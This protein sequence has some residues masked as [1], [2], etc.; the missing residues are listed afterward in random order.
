MDVHK[1]YRFFQ[2]KFRLKRMR[3][4]SSLF[5]IDDKTRI[6]DVGGGKEN[7]QLIPARPWLTIVNIDARPET[8]GKTQ[9]EVGDGCALSFDN[10]A[11]DVAYSNSV[12]EHVGDWKSQIKFADEIRR[13]A[14]SYYVQTPNRR[15]FM[16]PHLL[17]PFIHFFPKTLQ[18]ILLKNFTVWGL[19][20]RPNRDYVKCFLDTTQ[21]LTVEQMRTLFPDAEIRREKWFG[22][23]KSIIA[24]RIKKA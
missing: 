8:Q 10:F 19:I 23:T 22:M 21:L 24:A 12:I 11:F 7:W 1:V 6:V 9:I 18:L 4:F 16:E 13:V 20:T 5:S 15:F 2:R 3:E 14:P 17:T